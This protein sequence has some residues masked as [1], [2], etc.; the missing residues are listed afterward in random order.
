M[1]LMQIVKI[2]NEKLYWY[3]CSEHK[4]YGTSNRDICLQCKEDAEWEDYVRDRDGN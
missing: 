1:R 2:H 3:G 4:E